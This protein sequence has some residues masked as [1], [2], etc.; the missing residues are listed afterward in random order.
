MKVKF[1]RY[2]FQRSNIC[3]CTFC[4]PAYG[5]VRKVFLEIMFSMAFEYICNGFVKSVMT[6]AKIGRFARQVTTAED[7]Y[8]MIINTSLICWL[9][10]EIT[11]LFAP[12]EIEREIILLF[13]NPEVTNYIIT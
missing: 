9:N 1:C 2:Y 5:V 12:S 6:Y 11:L 10:S 13:R 8:S 3:R 7:L 4:Q